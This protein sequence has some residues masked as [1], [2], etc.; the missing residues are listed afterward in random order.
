MF[1]KYPMKVGISQRIIFHHRDYDSLEHGWYNLFKGHTIY[2]IPNRLDQDFHQISKDLDLFVISGG[3]DT[4]IRKI[5]ETKIASE[6]LLQKKPILGICRGAFFLTI[7]LGG[8]IKECQG[9]LR[10]DHEIFVGDSVHSVN[11]FHSYQI[12]KIPESSTSIA[13]DPE[14]FCEAW[15]DGNISAMVWHPERMKDHFIPDIIKKSINI[16]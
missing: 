7:L 10:T 13:V 15:I 16:S 11:S 5:V 14:G 4:E 6:M 9:H 8:T 1:Y 12:S 2:P 3:N